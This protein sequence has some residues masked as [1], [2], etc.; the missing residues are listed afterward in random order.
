MFTLGIR[1]IRIGRPLIGLVVAYA[2][3]AHGLLFA[4]GGFAVGLPAGA[5]GF[6][7]CLHDDQASPEIPVGIPGQRDCNHCVFC[8]V[9]TQP[10]LLPAQPPQLVGVAFAILRV[11]WLAGQPLIP[12]RSPYSIAHPR[13]PPF[14]A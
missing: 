5:P 6:E 3:A 4:F 8:V 7:L 1:S 9:G 12:S 2:V 11:G 13:G 10:A 14:R